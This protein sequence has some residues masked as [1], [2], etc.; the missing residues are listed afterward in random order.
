[1]KLLGK[2]PVILF[3][4]MASLALAQTEGVVILS[5]TV[6]GNQEQPNVLYIVPWQQASDNTI[7]YQPLATK[8]NRDVFEH[9]ERPEHIRELGYLEQLTKRDNAEPVQ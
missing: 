3:A 8:L 5:D 4:A 2:I 9:V 1:M 7:L 6:T